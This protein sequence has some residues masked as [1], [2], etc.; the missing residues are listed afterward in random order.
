MHSILRGSLDD[1]AG[2]HVVLK[3]AKDENTLQPFMY[4]DRTPLASNLQVDNTSSTNS[5]DPI[6]TMFVLSKLSQRQTGGNRG[7]L[8]NLES[9]MRA[10]QPVVDRLYPLSTAGSGTGNRWAC[11]LLRFAFW[12]K[13]VED[14]SPLA[15]SPIRAARIFGEDSGRNML[16]GTRSHPTQLFASLYDRLANVLTS[17]GFCYCVNP[18]DCQVLHSDAANADCS[19]L[20]TIRSLYDQRYRRIRL[21]SR[22]GSS[23]GQQ[24]DWP[25]E[26]GWMR[27]KSPNG[28]RN[29][30]SDACNVLDRLPPFRYAYKPVGKVGKPVDKRTSLDEGG[31]CHM[32]RAAGWNPGM[33]AVTSSYACKRIHSNYTHVVAR[34]TNP[35]TNKYQVRTPQRNNMHTDMVLFYATA[36]E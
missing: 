34:C 9:E 30:P 27:D 16:R 33:S 28:G 11:P 2:D 36:M 17:N 20:E 24:L 15:P 3:V 8:Y 10:E 4:V 5:Q 26:A 13:V 35:S 1:L 32:G 18:V 29:R 7:W 6:E 22:G 12:S 21:L 31:S 25:F 14:F 19:L 23:C